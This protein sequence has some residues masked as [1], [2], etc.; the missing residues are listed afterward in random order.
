MNLKPEIE[1]LRPQMKEHQT[2]MDN[3]PLE[4]REEM[5]NKVSLIISGGTNPADTLISDL[6]ASELREYVSLF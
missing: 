4:P 1:V 3:K 5:W 2:K 6:Q